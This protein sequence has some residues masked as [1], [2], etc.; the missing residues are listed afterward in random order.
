MLRSSEGPTRRSWR[1]SPRRAILIID[2]YFDYAASLR[3]LIELYGHHADIATDGPSGLELASTRRYDV[4]VC[5]IGLPGM[6]GYEV[7]RQIR[8]QRAT[9]DV[10]IIAVTVY[11][12]AEVKRRSFAAGFDAHLVKSAPVANTLSGLGIHIPATTA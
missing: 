1:A 3:D 7:A 6:N 11:D 5:D 10:S 9:A 2:S 4:I 8:T 12:S